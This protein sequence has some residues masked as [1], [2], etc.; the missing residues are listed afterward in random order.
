MNWVGN[1]KL[2]PS[3]QR[4]ESNIGNAVA[5]AHRPTKHTTFSRE[6]RSTQ[7]RILNEFAESGGEYAGDLLKSNSFKFR[8]KHLKVA[9]SFIEGWG[10]FALENIKEGE[11]VIEY[12]GQSIR[13]TVSEIREKKYIKLG[14]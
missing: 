6:A 13:A 11:M 1:L 3:R 8:Q 10:L 7:L 9:R 12:V 4:Q 14:A 2:T 5:G